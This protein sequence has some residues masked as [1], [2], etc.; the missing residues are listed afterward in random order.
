MD[1]HPLGY[2]LRQPQSPGRARAGGESCWALLG[3]VFCQ[4]QS[5][6]KGRDRPPQP[7]GEA[8]G[9]GRG[10][11]FW[12]GVRVRVEVGDLDLNPLG[13]KPGSLSYQVGQVQGVEL[14]RWVESWCFE[15]KSA[16]RGRDRSSQS[17]GE[18]G[19]WGRGRGRAQWQHPQCQHPLP[20]SLHFP[21]QSQRLML[22]HKLQVPQQGTT[23]FSRTGP[24]PR[25]PNLPQ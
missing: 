16:P 8:G 17:P 12:A 6:Q 24:L 20:R 19:G 1:L 21:A 3:L 7:P 9:G 13:Y 22:R 10:R 23:P 11:S 5:A 4:F 25:S 18:A 2:E 15:L 14:L